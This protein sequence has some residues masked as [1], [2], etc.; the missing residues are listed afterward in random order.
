MESGETVFGA[1]LFGEK[2]SR[3]PGHDDNRAGAQN[4]HKVNPSLP[5]RGTISS[6]NI[7]PPSLLSAP[8]APAR[9]A[10][11]KAAAPPSPLHGSTIAIAGT[12]SV[13]QASVKQRIENLGAKVATTVQQDTDCLIATQ[14]DYDKQSTKV[15][16]A[17]AKNVPIVSI[18]WLDECESSNSKVN[19][20]KHLVLSANASAGQSQSNGA[21]KTGTKSKRA[22]SPDPPATAPKKQKKEAHDPVAKV[23]DGQN[24]KSSTIVIPLDEYCPLSNYNV[25]V[26]D[27]GTIYDA[28]LNQTNASANN[29]KFY[30]IQVRQ[31]LSG[32]NF[33]R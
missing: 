15:K 19:T 28:A 30:K 18:D 3:P 32:G 1:S 13:S 20:M 31:S 25:H 26:G 24:A 29:N 21:A 23:G 2:A 5:L 11:K 9:R 16:A 7:P 10:A 33:V 27:D 17:I 4:A 12:F 22:A 6:Q 14:A 8:M